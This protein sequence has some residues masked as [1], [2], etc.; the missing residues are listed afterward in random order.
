MKNVFWLT[1]GIGIGFAAAHVIAN[2]PK[3]Q[4]FFA[5]VDAKA[6][7]FAAAIVDGYKDREAEL[8]ATVADAEATIADLRDRAN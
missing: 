5:E 6:H 8:R 1:T 2:N 3:G 7:E 4:A